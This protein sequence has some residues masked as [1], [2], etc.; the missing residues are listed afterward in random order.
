VVPAIHLRP[1]FRT[2]RDKGHFNVKP[3]IDNLMHVR[4]ETSN[5]HGISGYLEDE[6]VAGRIYEALTAP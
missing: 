6:I 1:G 2:G 4:N 5:H 3:A